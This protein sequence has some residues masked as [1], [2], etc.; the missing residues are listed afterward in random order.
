MDKNKI[1]PFNELY[2]QEAV[3]ED[4]ITGAFAEATNKLNTLNSL[5]EFPLS[6]SF[7]ISFLGEEFAMKLIQS[8][9]Y[10]HSYSLTQYSESLKVILYRH[11]KSSVL[12]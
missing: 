9:G 5:G 7:H 8:Y 10:S 1:I 12:V 2:S 11:I 6:V 4:F 3:N